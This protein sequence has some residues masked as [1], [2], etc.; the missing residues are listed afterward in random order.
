MRIWFPWAT[1]RLLYTWSLGAQYYALMAPSHS[2]CFPVIMCK[3]WFV[4]VVRTQLSW[5]RER[6][7]IFLVWSWISQP[8]QKGQSGYPSMGCP[9]QHWHDCAILCT[10]R[11]RSLD[12]PKCVWWACQVN[13]TY[14]QGMLISCIYMSIWWCFLMLS[15]AYFVP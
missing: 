15:F 8:L 14:V 12:G 10:Q 13:T 4:V 1:T 3:A 5:G 7:S 2:L 9:K 11:I 6:M